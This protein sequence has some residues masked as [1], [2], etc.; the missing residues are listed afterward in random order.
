MVLH[1]L[2]RRGRAHLCRRDELKRW[3]RAIHF[4]GLRTPSAAFALLAS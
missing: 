2:N 3:R 4:G 1:D